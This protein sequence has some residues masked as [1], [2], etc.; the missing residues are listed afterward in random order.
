MS[1][2]FSEMW[3]FTMTML[4]KR[5]MNQRYGK[6][7][8]KIIIKNAKPLCQKMFEDVEDIGF[9]NPMKHNLYGSFPLMAIWKASEGQISIEDYSKMINE[10]MSRPL[11]KRIISDGNLNVESDRI[12][13]LKTYKEN[14]KWADDHPEYKT[15][16]FHFDDNKHEK[17]LYHY[18]TYCPLHNFAKQ[19]GFLDVLPIMCNM[20]YITAENMHSIL[21]RKQTLATGGTMC[22]YWFVPD[23]LEE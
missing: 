8:T 23:Q 1:M 19:Y 20:D 5:P 17:G 4:I 21:H 15:W 12:K 22:D 2:P 6:K 18:F 16:D 13:I 10:T 14:K 11:I 3:W 7:E 9:D